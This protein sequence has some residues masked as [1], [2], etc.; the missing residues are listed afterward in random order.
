MHI[1]QGR[2]LFQPYSFYIYNTKLAIFYTRLIYIISIPNLF[3]IN[4]IFTHLSKHKLPLA[5][6]FH[7][8]SLSS[9]QT[10]KLLF[11]SFL[12]TLKTPLI[13]DVR[14]SSSRWVSGTPNN[15][16]LLASIAN[17]EMIRSRRYYWGIHHTIP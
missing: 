8:L 4:Y 1:L 17:L 13:I 6:F 11:S 16:P 12:E 5:F 7:K 10:T 3:T 9:R 14:T 2:A 15:V